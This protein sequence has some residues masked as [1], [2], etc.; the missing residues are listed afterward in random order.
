ML[1]LIG[2][3]T[4]AEQQ[5]FITQYWQREHR[6][7]QGALSEFE[8]PVNADELAGLACESEVVS[9]IVS[10][11]NKTLEHGPFSQQRL[12]SF[13]TS[14]STLLVQGVELYV[15]ELTALRSAFDFIPRW[16]FEDVMVSFATPNGGV[17]PHFDQ[18]DVFLVQ[19]EGSREWRVGQRCDEHSEIE[20]SS[21]QQ[22]LTEFQPHAS[23]TLNKGDILYVPPGLAHWGISRDNSICYSIGFRAPSGKELANEWAYWLDTQ[24]PRFQD[25]PAFYAAQSEHQ[26]SVEAVQQAKHL[27][28]ELL[29]DPAAVADALGAFQSANPNIDEIDPPSWSDLEDEFARET[30]LSRMPGA[31]SF[32]YCDETNARLYLNGQAEDASG[33]SKEWLE[34][35]CSAEVLGFDD[36]RSHCEHKD[37]RIRGCNKALLLLAL[38]HQV[39]EF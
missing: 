27:L 28:V 39:Y 3:A 37:D 14:D 21:G 31:R 19:G 18:Y 24:E 38:Q 22:V 33:A 9:R 4:A 15:P 30:E 36:I 29:D 25:P 2:L 13:D 5:Q 20:S 17:G 10:G 16:R 12:Q 11:P 32:Y 26:I 34:L 35:L 6:F 1:S 8:D 7:F 23:Y